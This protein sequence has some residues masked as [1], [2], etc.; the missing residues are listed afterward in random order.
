MSMP[1]MPTPDMNPKFEIQK[2]NVKEHVIDQLLESIAKEEFGLAEI[3]D[4]EADKIK[5]VVH[6]YKC[7]GIEDLVDIDKSVQKTLRDIIKKEI[8]LEFKFENILE[9][10]RETKKR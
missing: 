5:A 3:L 7:N 10:I 6:E 2:G 1:N 9:L 4:A 8:L